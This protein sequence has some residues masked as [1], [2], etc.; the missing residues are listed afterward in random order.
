MISYRNTTNEIRESGIKTAI[1][2]VGSIEQHASH[3]PVGTDYLIAQK[4][5]EAVAE[6]I[7]AYLL[8]ALP[9]ST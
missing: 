1:I 8:P 7:N 5:G 6:R 9:F 3:L 4:V 2:P